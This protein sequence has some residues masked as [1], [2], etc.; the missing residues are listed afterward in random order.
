MFLRRRLPSRRL[1]NASPIIR[2]TRTSISPIA[3]NESSYLLSTESVQ[4]ESVSTQAQPGLEIFDTSSS[5]FG[6]APSLL[7]G[8]LPRWFGEE[9][10]LAWSFLTRQKLDLRLGQRLTDPLSSPWVASAA[11]STSTRESARTGE[12]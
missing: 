4:L 3:R 9:T 10:Q 1:N 7:A 6:A 11:E 5:S 12:G 2:L 8:A